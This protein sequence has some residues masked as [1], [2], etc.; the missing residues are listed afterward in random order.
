MYRI[1]RISAALA[2]SAA[3]CFSMTGISAAYAEN[4]NVGSTDKGTIR[5]NMTAEQISAEMGLGINLGNTMEAYWLDRNRVDSGAQTIGENKPGNYETCWGAVTTTQEA[6]D[7]MKEAGFNTLRVPVYWGNMMENDGT[8]TINE[9]Y[10][11]RVKEIVDYGRNADMYV[12]INMHHYDEF[13]IRRYTKDKDIEGCAETVKNLWTQIA[14]YFEDYSDFLIFEGFNEYLGGGPLDSNGNVI[15]LPRSEGFEWTNALNQAFVDA[16]RATGGNN[17]QRVLIASGYWTNIDLTTSNSF[18]MPTD[19]A[20]N[21]MMVSVH[22][23]DNSMYWSNKIGGQ[24]WENYSIDQCEKL[25]KAFADKGI[26]V[27]VGECTSIYNR[28]NFASNASIKTSSEAMDHMLRLI[29]DYGFTPVL[30]DTNNNFY[31]R[32]NCKIKNSS[33]AEVIKKLAEEIYVEPV[34]S[35]EPSDSSSESS[36]SS[37]VDSTIDSVPDSEADSVSDSSSASDST[38]VSDSAVASSSVTDSK[39]DS[40]VSSSQSASTAAQNTSKASS[41]ANQNNGNSAKTADENANT[42]AG[43]AISLVLVI[44]AAAIA[45]SRKRK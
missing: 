27:F 28:S 9:E 43:G 45:V 44:S 29:T 37:E 4:V 14:E 23:V 18:V 38:S 12:V 22:Y 17:S 19:T 32:T 10:I 39:N 11:A 5:E 26:P 6:V 2:V 25:K 3:L 1:K 8:F 41:A 7:G 21:R 13:I 35:P 34:P 24:E 30:W 36:D 33:D 40:V 15:D 20:E 16:V 31:D 42:G